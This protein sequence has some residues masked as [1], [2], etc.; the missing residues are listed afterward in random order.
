MD[1]LFDT[2]TQKPFGVENTCLQDLQQRASITL[3][4]IKRIYQT[5]RKDRILCRLYDSNRID[6][7]Q[8]KQ[9]FL[10]GKNVKFYKARF[11][12]K[13]PHFV[14]RVQEHLVNLPFFR[15]AE[16]TYQQ[17]SQGWYTIFTT[18]DNEL[19]IAAETAL[20]ENQTSLNKLWGNNRTLVHINSTNGDVLSY[21]WSIDFFDTT[22]DGQ[23]DVLKSFRQVGSTLKPFIYSYLF[24][25][26]PS[27][28]N[29]FISDYPLPNLKLKNHDNMFRGKTTISKALWW[30]RNLPAVRVFFALGGGSTFVP[31]LRSLGL[32]DLD[33]AY[34]YSY[35]LVLGAD[36]TTHIQLAQAYIQLSTTG[37]SYPL[38]NPIKEIRTNQG[39]VLYQ[40]PSTRFV[41]Q[42]PDTV[43][44]MIRQILSDTQYMPTNRRWLRDLPLK[45]LALK[46]GTSNIKVW[47][48]SYPRDGLSV[49]YSSTDIVITWAW[50]TN[51][52]AMW[53]KGFWGEINH[54]TLKSY[55]QTAVDLKKITDQPRITQT[56]YT[57]SGWYAGTDYDWFTDQQKSYLR[58]GINK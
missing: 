18:L 55:L 28:L 49:I 17:L 29:S 33:P 46:T 32:T 43:A 23:V 3:P 56:A 16:L 35:P 26:Y 48:N 22:I 2:L 39:D 1:F 41:K 19:Q 21:V 58:G 44:D 57:T 50:N 14:Y 40:K 38:I 15:K 9:I 8:L 54:L 7:T 45:N 11:S 34:P 52:S 27:K 36:A 4:E 53:P 25:H 51:G 24:M 37:S 13:A 10:E 31:Y 30:S 47:K 42:I 12:I 20:T 6:I 5:G